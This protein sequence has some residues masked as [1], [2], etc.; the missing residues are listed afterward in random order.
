[1]HHRGSTLH[2]KNKR[3]SIQIDKPPMSQEQNTGGGVIGV[4][5]GLATSACNYTG[6]RHMPW[7]SLQK[8]LHNTYISYYAREQTGNMTRKVF[9]LKLVPSFL[10]SIV[11]RIVLSNLF[12]L[13]KLVS[14]WH[15]KET[16]EHVTKASMSRPASDFIISMCSKSNDICVNMLHDFE[17]K[18]QCCPSMAI[19]PEEGGYLPVWWWQT[20]LY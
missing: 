20:G 14:V 12:M 8:T 19:C 1:M 13:K 9:V 11:S 18:S 10:H 5:E 15:I 3:S 7:P 2:T 4:K 17:M 16:E 6:W